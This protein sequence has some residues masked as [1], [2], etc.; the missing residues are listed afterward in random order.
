MTSTTNN[1]VR[2]LHHIAKDIKGDWK[3]VYFGA[4]PYLKALAQLSTINDN[5][6]CDSAKSIIIYFLGNAT[7]WLGPKAKEIKAEL[8]KIA[9]VK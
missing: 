9:V 4:V 2:P 1:T 7:T 8:K 6:G 3:N 5:Y